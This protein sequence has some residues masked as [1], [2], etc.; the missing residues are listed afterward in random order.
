MEEGFPQREIAHS[1]YT[2]QQQVECHEEIIVGINRYAQ[3]AHTPIP[4]LKIDPHVEREQIERVKALRL[5]RN[6]T[7]AENALQSIRQACANDTNLMPLLLDAG[8]ADCTL[9]EICHVFRDVYGAY[10][11]PGG[12]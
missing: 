3:Q 10:R 1:A 2:T 6:A 4:T 5:R 12:F 8:R 11:D 9:G 7:T